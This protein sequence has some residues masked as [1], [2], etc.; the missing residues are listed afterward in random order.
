MLAL[1]NVGARACAIRGY[2]GVRMLDPTGRALPLRVQRGHGFF[3]DTLSAPRTVALVPG[4]SAH[5]GISFVTNREYA[6]AHV[7]H[8]AGAA[9]SAVP[10]GSRW[11]RVSLRGAPR[12]SPCG[13]QLVV[14]PV[15]A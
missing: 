12:I 7:C 8:T 3:P 5:F 1:R 15:H 11:Q 9:M 6:G 2:P 10:P 4:T 14:S 13:R